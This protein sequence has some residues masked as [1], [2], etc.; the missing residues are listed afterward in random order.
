[1]DLN[2]TYKKKESISE[3][4]FKGSY[5]ES[6]T[7]GRSNLTKQLYN[8]GKSIIYLFELTLGE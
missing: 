8:S 4:N 3:I 2:K 7:L 1:M 6:E 5:N